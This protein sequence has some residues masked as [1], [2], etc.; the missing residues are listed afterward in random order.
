MNFYSNSKL[1][2]SV[3]YQLFGIQSQL[4]FCQTPNSCKHFQFHVFFLHVYKSS[5]HNSW[6][7]LTSQKMSTTTTK[8]MR[9]RRYLMFT[10]YSKNTILWVVIK[11]RSFETSLLIHKIDITAQKL[12]VEI[13]KPI[14]TATLH[15]CYLKAMY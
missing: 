4:T 14:K 5:T 13:S 12:L 9:R 10:R 11:D 3:F 7:K 15:S 1:L 2:Y 8:T 6:Q